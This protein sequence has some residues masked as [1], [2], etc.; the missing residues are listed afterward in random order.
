MAIYIII[1]DKKIP[2]WQLRQTGCVSLLNV[3]VTPAASGV[4]SFV[5]N[6]VNET[7]EAGVALVFAEEL[8]GRA[9][10]FILTVADFLH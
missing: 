4:N 5:R 6:L 9:L 3:L 1:F 10:T 8:A 7:A 2:A